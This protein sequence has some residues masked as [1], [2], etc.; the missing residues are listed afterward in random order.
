MC[1]CVQYKVYKTAVP[2]FEF[3]FLNSLFKFILVCVCVQTD[4]KIDREFIHNVFYVLNNIS[5]IYIVLIYL[6][7]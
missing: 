2:L 5:I 6:F 1:V 4:R 7:L 3:I